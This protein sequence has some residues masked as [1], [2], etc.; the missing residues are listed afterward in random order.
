MAAGALRPVRTSEGRGVGADGLQGGVALGARG[1]IRPGGELGSEDNQR[2]HCGS[3]GGFGTPN[4]C[5]CHAQQQYR[6]DNR[7]SASN[8]AALRL[9]VLTGCPPHTGHREGL[10][11]QLNGSAGKGINVHG[12]PRLSDCI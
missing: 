4:G 8:Q 12:A 9:T 6:A 5:V 3:V 2:R 1:W 11:L 10:M 7:A